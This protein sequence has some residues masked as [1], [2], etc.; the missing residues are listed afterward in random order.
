MNTIQELEK[1]EAD[2]LLA[3]R[4]IPSFQ[5]GDTLRVN[6]RIKEGERE[7]VQDL[8]SRFRK[9]PDDTR[10]I[11][12]VEKMS[13]NTAESI[14]EVGMGSILLCRPFVIIREVGRPSRLR[15]VHMDG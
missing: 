12:S 2:R 11:A 15:L 10:R 6:V 7:R 14:N 13:R 3:L 4:K 1:E 8:V 9:L 5:A